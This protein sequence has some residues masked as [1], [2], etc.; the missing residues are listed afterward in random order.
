LG[1]DSIAPAGFPALSLLLDATRRNRQAASRDSIRRWAIAAVAAIVLAFASWAFS[2]SRSA[3]TSERELAQLKPTI[4]QALAVQRDLDAADE[5]LAVMA[6]LEPARMHRARFLARL[7]RALPDSAFLAAV[8]FDA[9][10]TGSLSGYAPRATAVLALLE[11]TH[12][13]QGPTIEG[14]VTREVIAG[15]DL[16]RFS[17][18]F[19]LPAEAHP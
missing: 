15:R 12:L 17:I 14:S 11:R 2:L 4:E 8:H 19:R 1:C 6:N 10:G 7:T 16:G 5:A 18:R 9:D 13:A 3:R